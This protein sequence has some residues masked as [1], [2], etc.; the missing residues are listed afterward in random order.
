MRIF[1]RQDAGA[2]FDKLNA[3]GL[4]RMLLPQWLGACQHPIGRKC[5]VAAWPKLR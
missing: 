4:E 1:L 2:A 3:F 5:C